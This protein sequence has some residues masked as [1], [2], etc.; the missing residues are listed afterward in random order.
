MTL[1]PLRDY[2][3]RAVDL[4]VDAAHRWRRV[5]PG[6]GL[7]CV[8]PTGAGKTRL[9]LE[10]ATRS[11]MKGR[12]VLWLAPRTELIDQ[13]VERL[14]AA[15]WPDVRI[16]QADRPRGEG[17]I[18]VAS[19][20]TLVA[21]DE[22][23]EADLVVMDE[24]R[25]MAAKEWH[26]LAARYLDAVRIGLDATPARADGA[27]LADL[28]DEIVEV[29]T[30]SELIADGWLLPAQI[31]APAKYEPKLAADPVQ[32]YLEH[33]PHG[34][35]LCFCQSRRHAKDVAAAFRAA[36]IS[37]VAV[38]SY[39][40]DDERLL[41]VAGIRDGSID[42]LCN[43][44]LFTEGFDA[45]GIN[46]II[47]ARGVSNGWT[48]LQ[49]LGRGLRP[50]HGRRYAGERCIVLDLRGHVHRPGFGWLDDARTWHLEGR[51]LRHVEGLPTAVQCPQ[52]HG[53]SR[54]GGTCPICGAVKPDP[55][56]PKVSKREL[57]ERRRER[58]PRTGRD[59][60]LWRELVLTARERGYKPGWACFRYKAKTGRWPR[61]GIK[62]VE[63]AEQA[64][65]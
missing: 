14:H 49:M 53:W 47:I 36:G 30:I 64:E 1:D 29:A 10:L 27:G 57:A 60:E 35:A 2:Q 44:Q 45:P 51:P 34:R 24:C 63:Q 13:P 26:Q 62:Q 42:V 5:K 56:P 52:C 32:A 25:H 21:R 28:F 61:W 16:L 40:S 37:S 18:T 11:I 38:D 23:P 41:A 7:L 54:G 46:T 59:W 6:Y 3:A 31:I 19:I 43:V 39:S 8:A 33:A 55:P 50:G 12:Q 4:L 22:A 20:Q 48:W 17:P 58:Q 65:E 15:G 9:A